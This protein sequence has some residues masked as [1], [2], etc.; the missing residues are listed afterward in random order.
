MKETDDLKELRTLAEA[1]TEGPWHI[2]SHGMCMVSIKDF[3]PIFTTSDR[4]NDGVSIRHEDTGN[5]SKWRNDNDATYI[6][7]FHPTRILR[8]LDRIEQLESKTVNKDRTKVQVRTLEELL[9]HHSFEFPD[10]VRRIL[11]FSAELLEHYEALES[12]VDDTLK[13]YESEPKLNDLRS[14]VQ[15]WHKPVLK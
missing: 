7:T 10:D 4:M 11:E 3:E 9:Q 2:D 14:H 12:A 13:A 8:M 5:L 6:A 15:S 1:A